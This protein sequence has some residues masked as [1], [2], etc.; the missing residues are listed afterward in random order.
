M[1]PE[2]LSQSPEDELQVFSELQQITLE[3]EVVQYGPDI[4]IDEEPLHPVVELPVPDVISEIWGQFGTDI[5]QKCGNPRDHTQPSYCHLSPLARQQVAT[6]HIKTNELSRFFN[7]VQWKQATRE[8][9]DK[10][11]DACFWSL[12]EDDVGVTPYL[13]HSSKGGQEP[14]ARLSY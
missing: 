2:P 3:D 14:M 6:E 8:Q 13:P 11:F 12:S 10:A 4:G 1:T 7:R 5:L 9:W